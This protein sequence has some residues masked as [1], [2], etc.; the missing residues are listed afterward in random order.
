MRVK[1]KVWERKIRPVLSPIM[2]ITGQQNNLVQQFNSLNNPTFE[3]I[4]SHSQRL[5][6]RVL[7]NQPDISSLNIQSLNQDYHFSRSINSCRES[8][9]NLE[10]QRSTRINLLLTLS[11]RSRRSDL[12][13]HSNANSIIQEEITLHSIRRQESSLPQ[14]ETCQPGSRYSINIKT[15]NN[16]HISYSFVILYVITFFVLSIL[17]L[18]RHIVNSDSEKK[19][20]IISIWTTYR[21]VL[22]IFPVAWLYYHEEAWEYTL[23]KI[24]QFK[25]NI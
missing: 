10:V 5:D 17:H 8:S 24:R 6:N 3:P 15:V 4:Q 13:N 14:Q 11:D 12:Q 9:R 21:T 7:S 22:Y 25:N 1:K 23:H 20:L 18:L 19:Y 2:T 16:I